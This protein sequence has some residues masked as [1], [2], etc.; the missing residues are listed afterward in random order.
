M[1]SFR[2][3]TNGARKFHSLTRALA[4]R[5]ARLRRPQRFAFAVNGRVYSRPFVDYRAFP[6]GLDGRTGIQVEGM[7]LATAQR[8][9]REIRRG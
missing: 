2:L 4:R 1:L 5:G 3:T 9:A 8:L 7:T 6:N